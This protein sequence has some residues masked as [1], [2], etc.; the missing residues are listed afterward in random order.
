MGTRKLSF[1]AH[2]PERVYLNKCPT[3]ST[4]GDG[5]SFARNP[6]AGRMLQRLRERLDET[7]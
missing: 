2:V 4:R 6:K 5:R 7:S 1:L 3:T